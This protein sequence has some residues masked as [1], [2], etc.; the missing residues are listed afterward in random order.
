MPVPILDTHLHLIYLDRFDYPWLELE[1]DIKAQRTIEG[2]FDEAEKLGIEAALHMEVDVAEPEIEAETRFVTRLDDRLA[3]AIAACR[4]ESRNFGSQFETLAAIEGVKG[5]RRILHT[6]P[7]GLS[8]TSVF[9]DNVRRL[10]EHDFTF[11]LCLRADQLLPVGA[12]LIDQC[13]EVQFVLDHCGVPDAVNGD[14]TAWRNAIAELAR[15]PNLACKISGIIAYAGP[16]PTAAVLRPYVEHVIA[17]F[18]WNRVVWGSDHPV[19]TRYANLTRWVEISREIVAGASEAEQK[20]LF[21]DN[22]RLLYRL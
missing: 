1:P 18:G 15:R 3:G 8:Q 22:A 10:A 7:D 12:P 2:Y 6:Q 17:S 9:R 16:N 11:D 21:A 19:C 13:N 14:F 5:F 4:P 20:R